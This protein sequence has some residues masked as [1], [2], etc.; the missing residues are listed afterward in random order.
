[1]QPL[2]QQADHCGGLLQVSGTITAVSMAVVL[3]VG[4]PWVAIVGCGLVGAGLAM[5]VPILYGAASRVPGITP[6]ALIA[7]LPRAVHR[8]A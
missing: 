1:V 8:A 2:D 3:I 5:I 7:L 4:Q 6:A